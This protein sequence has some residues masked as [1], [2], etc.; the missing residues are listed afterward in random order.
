MKCLLCG[1]VIYLWMGHTPCCQ[2]LSFNVCFE[3]QTTG[4]PLLRLCANSYVTAGAM[5]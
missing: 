3:E 2:H 4:S 1:I 5:I